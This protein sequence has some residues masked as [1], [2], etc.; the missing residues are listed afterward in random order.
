MMDM[1]FSFSRDWIYSILPLDPFKDTIA[2]LSSGK[3]AEGLSWLN[4][5]IPVG[6]FVG[7]LL[8]WVT[9]IATYYVYTVVLRWLKV[10]E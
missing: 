2:G 1:L 3:I 5:F 10:I 7:I 4:W 9:C 6:D 8:I